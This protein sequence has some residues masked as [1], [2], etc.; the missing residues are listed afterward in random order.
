LKAQKH[1]QKKKEHTNTDQQT[2]NSRPVE[3]ASLYIKKRKRK[4]KKAKRQKSK[5]IFDEI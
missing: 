4:K 1:S 5:R 3:I 2:K